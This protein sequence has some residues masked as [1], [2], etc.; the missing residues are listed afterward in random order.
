MPDMNQRTVI[1]F[2]ALIVAPLLAR[3]EEVPTARI[4]ELAWAEIRTHAPLKAEKSTSCSARKI[5]VPRLSSVMQCSLHEIRLSPS[6]GS[7]PANQPVVCYVLYREGAIHVVAWQ[8]PEQVLR[9]WTVH[10]GMLFFVEGT[11][12][13]F[14]RA[15]VHRV[16]LRD[17]VFQQDSTS[18][19]IAPDPFLT[20][21]GK[22]QLLVYSLAGKRQSRRVKVGHIADTKAAQLELVTPRKVEVRGPRASAIVEQAIWKELS[23]DDSRIA[24]NHTG[25]SAYEVIVPNLE[26]QLGAKLYRIEAEEGGALLLWGAPFA[27]VRE[28]KISILVNSWWVGEML[29]HRGALYYAVGRGGFHRSIIISHRYVAGEMKT[30]TS[31]EF[32]LVNLSLEVLRSGRIRVSSIDVMGWKTRR[33]LGFLSVRGD[34]ELVVVDNLGRIVEPQ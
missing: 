7:A 3:A 28:G 21:D 24:L 2:F 11:G 5:K 29:V 23:S 26:E 16:Q 8:N 20:V 15:S 1:L 4:E 19:F 31:G 34:D 9:G 13:M 27:L 22:H 14:S 17:G 12:W 6:D 25:C 33:I 32:S 18:K 30:R 10:D